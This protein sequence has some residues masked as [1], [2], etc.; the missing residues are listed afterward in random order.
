MVFVRYDGKMD[1]EEEFLY[2]TSLATTATGADIFNVVDYFQQKDGIRWENCVCV[3]TVNAPAMLG[4]RH[5]FAARVKQV[6]LTCK[7]STAL[8]TVRTLLCNICRWI[9]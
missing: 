2:F 9:Y 7:S 1:L 8:C 3:C 5:V 4:A 6:N